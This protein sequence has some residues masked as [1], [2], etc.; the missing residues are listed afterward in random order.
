MSPITATNLSCPSMPD[1]N[2]G[3][4]N[5]P[6]SAPPPSFAGDSIARAGAEIAGGWLGASAGGG[7][8]E[9]AGALVGALVGSVFAP[10]PGTFAGEAL[11]A[12]AGGL[13]GA[14]GGGIA[15]ATLG[16]ALVNDA[17]GTA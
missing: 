11:G 8:G 9:Q 17:I 5:S 7:I 6:Q 10:G 2:E 12:T 1:S 15:G 16:N 13:A 3:K 14:I 4:P